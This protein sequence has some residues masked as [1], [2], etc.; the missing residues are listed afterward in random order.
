VTSPLLLWLSFGVGRGMPPCVQCRVR[1]CGC[2]PVVWSR[3]P[4]SFGQIWHNLWP[5]LPV[6]VLLWPDLTVDG[7]NPA[8][9]INKA[10]VLR[11]WCSLLLLTTVGA[12][13]MLWA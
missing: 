11:P 1:V 8:I 7:S 13:G 2:L 12:R 9:S 5:F 6:V 3:V 10:K 4:I